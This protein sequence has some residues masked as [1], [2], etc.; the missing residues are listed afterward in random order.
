MSDD[1]VEVFVFT[2]IRDSVGLAA[3]LYRLAIENNLPLRQ[4]A[5]A[6]MELITITAAYATGAEWET[7]HPALAEIKNHL[8][9]AMGAILD[10]NHPQAFDQLAAVEQITVTAIREIK[11]AA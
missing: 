6:T 1:P 10:G 4:I 11:V 2:H 3:R 7:D 9:L 5:S 8:A